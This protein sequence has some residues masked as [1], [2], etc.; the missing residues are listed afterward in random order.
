[1]SA[2][3]PRS[4]K[5]KVAAPP[6]HTP[7]CVSRGSGMTAGLEIWRVGATLHLFDRT[8]EGRFAADVATWT[9]ASGGLN[10][11]TLQIIKD[12]GTAGS[13]SSS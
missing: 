5:T 1:M 8:P 11:A 9:A 3:K 2:R 10:A 13:N 12:A 6:T 4:T 7:T